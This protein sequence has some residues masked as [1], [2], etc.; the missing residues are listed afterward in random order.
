MVCRAH[1]EWKVGVVAA[2][3]LVGIVACTAALAI[4]FHFGQFQQKRG[5]EKREAKMIT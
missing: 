2:S 5:R 1:I 4:F 3:V